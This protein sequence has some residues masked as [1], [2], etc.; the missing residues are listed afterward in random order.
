MRIDCTLNLT[1]LPL[2]P[3]VYWA[4]Y[5]NDETKVASEL[6][7]MPRQFAQLRIQASRVSL[8]GLSALS[9]VEGRC[10]VLFR[11]MTEG[12]VL[13]GRFAKPRDQPAATGAAGAVCLVRPGSVATVL[14]GILHPAGD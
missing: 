9:P 8:A 13:T 1:A 3:Q 14:Q 4:D 2:S 11:Q 10:E 12:S 5:G 6:R 7:A